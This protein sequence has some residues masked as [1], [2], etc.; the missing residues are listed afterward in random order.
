MINKVEW[1]KTQ[2]TN[3]ERD[4][5]LGIKPKSLPDDSEYS[6]KQ[7]EDGK[8]VVEHKPTGQTSRWPRKTQTQAAD[9]ALAL[10]E[11]RT[12]HATWFKEQSG[13]AERTVRSVDR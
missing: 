8:F 9:D 5:V 13:A 10:H 7:R 2:L 3:K 4:A 12:S 1:D 6:V 11:R